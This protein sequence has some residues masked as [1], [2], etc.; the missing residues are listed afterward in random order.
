[1]VVRKFWF[2]C[3]I[4]CTDLLNNFDNEDKIDGQILNQM[5]IKKEDNK[6]INLETGRTTEILE[7]LDIWN[8]KNVVEFYEWLD[9]STNQS[10]VEKACEYLAETLGNIFANAKF[11]D[12]L[13]N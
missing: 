8:E 4:L 6:K 1:M 10:T 7:H 13:E 12:V 9:I 2:W 3:Y 5:L 11:S